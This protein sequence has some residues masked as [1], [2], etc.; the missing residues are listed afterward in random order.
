MMDAKLAR[1]NQKFASLMKRLG[2]NV[3]GTKRHA[4]EVEM[5]HKLLEAEYAT[6]GSYF[7][8]VDEIDRFV[9]DVEADK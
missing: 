9:K 5:A 4:Y 7:K 8:V 2:S 1:L 3:K 6:P